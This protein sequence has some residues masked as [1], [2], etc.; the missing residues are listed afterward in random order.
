[1]IRRAGLRLATGA[2]LVLL[3]SV[4]VHVGVDL[5]PGDAATARLGPNATPERVEELRHR[6]GLDQ[7]VLARY[8]DWLGGVLRGDLGLSVTGKPVTEMLSDRVGNSVILTAVTLALLVP[9]SLGLGVFAATWR[10]RPVS[11]GALLLVSVPEFAVAGAL[12]LA[13]AVTLRWLPAV[14]LIPLGDSPLS[15]PE[16][17]V[18]PV[19][20][21]LGVGLSYAVRTIR[22]AAVTA[23]GSPYVEFLRLNG[24]SSRSVLRAAVLPA[25]LPVALQV[26]LVTGVGLVGGGVLVEKV[27]GYPGIGE[28]LVASVQ[29][30][31]LPVVQ[32]LVLALGSAML[33]ALAVAD[34]AVVLLTPRLRTQAVA[35]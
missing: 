16:A 25:V 8:L 35:A 34:L 21:L 27:F 4:L 18:L 30:G 24:I 5:L 22:S 31:D 2:G 33:V 6:L 11:V 17:L 23:F 15:H 10:G 3:L 28:L 19:L 20:A 14:S 29:T 26:W 7:P 13:F 9:L 1:M 32:A 12:A